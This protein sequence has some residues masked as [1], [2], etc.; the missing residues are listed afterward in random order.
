MVVSPIE[1][2]SLSS[3]NQECLDKIANKESL[4]AIYDVS[5]ADGTLEGAATI[6]FNLGESNNGKKVVVTH[7]KKDGTKELFNSTVENGVAT[8]RVESLSP[9]AI[10]EV[11]RFQDELQEIVVG[12]DKIALPFDDTNINN[13][14]I[15]KKKIKNVPVTLNDSDATMVTTIDNLPRGL[16]FDGN[17]I[18]GTPIVEDSEWDRNYYNGYSK[19]YDLKFKARK[20]N[21]LLVRNYTWYVHK[22]NDRDGIADSEE[23]GIKRS[24]NIFNAQVDRKPLVSDGKRLTVEDYKTKITN[25][26]ADGGVNVT[27][28]K[29]ANYAEVGEQSVILEFTIP[30]FEG[31][32]TAIIKVDVKKA[33]AEEFT[34]VEVDGNTIGVSL[35]DTSVNNSWIDKKEIKPVTITLSDSEAELLPEIENLP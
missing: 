3:E 32:G 20:G 30:G 19:K 33:V 16:S 21:V 18:T 12:G 10:T 15:N 7:F 31:K 28:T 34:I 22:D 5:V 17:I 8:V 24:E 13:D 27:V 23:V 1:K 26:P 29:D 35:D 2:A 11:S 6:K 25:F 4:L 9:F 14:W